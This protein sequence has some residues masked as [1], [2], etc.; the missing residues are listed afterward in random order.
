MKMGIDKGGCQQ[1]SLCINLWQIRCHD[2][3]IDMCNPTLPNE[4][5]DTGSTVRQVCIT[6]QK[7]IHVSIPVLRVKYAH[8]RTNPD[9][10]P[11]TRP[12]SAL[13]VTLLIND[14]SVVVCKNFNRF[15]VPT[16]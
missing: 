2:L 12:Q 7:V 13:A 9:A 15:I 8:L 14:Q 3:S 6:Y 10:A 11:L 4:D 5:V 16:A 1:I